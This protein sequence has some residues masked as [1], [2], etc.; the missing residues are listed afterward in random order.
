VDNDDNSDYDYLKFCLG[1]SLSVVP[2]II[3]LTFAPV[4]LNDHVGAL[5]NGF[6]FLSMC[7]FSAFFSDGIVNFLGYKNALLLGNIGNIIYLISYQILF[8]Y[9][10]FATLRWVYPA[11]SIIG[12]CSHALMWTAKVSQLYMHKNFYSMLVY[13]I[14]CLFRV[15]I[16]HDTPIS[17]LSHLI[18]V[19]Q[20]IVI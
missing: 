8:A 3:S 7:F 12:G 15:N 18:T 11:V 9:L 1:F 14:M 6:F 4:L 10:L 13:H 20:Y 5:G 2:V 19:P 16:M 17:L